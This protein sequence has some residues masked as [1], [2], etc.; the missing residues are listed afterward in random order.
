MHNWRKNMYLKDSVLSV[1]SAVKSLDSLLYKVSGEK[2]EKSDRWSLKCC[3]HQGKEEK[4]LDA[5]ARWKSMS[6]PAHTELSSGRLPGSCIVICPT[7]SCRHF[8]SRRERSAFNSQRRVETGWA[9]TPELINICL[10]IH[11]EGGVERRIQE[12]N[13]LFFS[14]LAL[15]PELKQHFSPPTTVL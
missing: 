5:T 6:S 10:Q 15:H 2:G 13:D 14:A 3:S 1:S 12:L 11:T 4:C 7:A 8:K 9:S